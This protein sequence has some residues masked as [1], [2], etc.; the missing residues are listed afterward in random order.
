MKKYLGDAVYVEWT[1]YDL[2]LT[3]EDGYTAS[4][5]IVLEP[6]VYDELVRFVKNLKG[7]DLPRT[8]AK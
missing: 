2:V 5:T 6:Q 3:T 1:G 8:E 7:L 4:N